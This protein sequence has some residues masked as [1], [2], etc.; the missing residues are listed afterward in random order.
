MTT[1]VAK[2][3]PQNAKKRLLVMKA[4]VKFC[5]IELGVLCHHDLKEMSNRT[6]LCV[7]TLR[8]LRKGKIST[9]MW[10]DTCLKLGTAVNAQI[11]W[12]PIE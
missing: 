8:N 5:M 9:R 1:K 12:A 10:T 7:T 6:Q 2:Q 11:Q 4:F 3:I